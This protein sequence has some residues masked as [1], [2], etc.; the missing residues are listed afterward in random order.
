MKKLA[1][2]AAVIAVGAGAYVLSGKDGGTSSNNELLEYIPADTLLFSGQLTPFPLEDYLYSMPMGVNSKLS[3]E[4]I[5]QAG[6]FGSEQERFFVS[7]Y[8]SYLMSFEN[9]GVFLKTFGLP[10][11]IES[12][13][14]TLGALP[15]FKVQIEDE[16]A[17]WSLLDKA[18][19][20]SGLV[21]KAESIKGQDYRAYSLIDEDESIDMVFSQKEGWLTVTLNTSFN[22]PELLETA[23]GL[24]KVE[25]PIS[26]SG[27]LEEIAS[28]HGFLKD[29]IS[30]INHVELVNGL[31]SSDG[32]MLAKQLTKLV[33]M[34]GS[35]EDPFAE[36]KTS[37]CKAEFNSIAANWPRSVMG[38]KSFS[39]DRKETNFDA[40][41]VIESNNQVILGAL[42][43][44]RGFIPSFSQNINDNVASLAFGMDV[45][46][47][48]PALSEIWKDLQT[49]SYQCEALAQMQ[50]GVSEQNPAMLGMMTGM[51]N[52]VKGIS[53][54]IVDFS[55]TDE[56]GEPGFK[57]LDALISLSA[58][59]PEML[60]NM[61]RPFVPQLANIQLE[62]NGDAID[63]SPY[64]MLPPEMGVT[65]QMAM[66]DN[67]L[68]IFSGDKGE[69]LADK[70]AAEKLEANGLNSVALDYQKLLTPVFSLIEESGEPIP[71]ELA[72]LKDYD[73][74]MQFGLDVTAKGISISTKANSKA[75]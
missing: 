26:D 22:K 1:I 61:V 35:G 44:M 12:Y 74:R 46:Q 8:K 2:A 18:S 4:Q 66:K 25:N 3:L 24:T 9:P 63:V 34:E 19:D 5:E 27:M 37:E 21:H 49:P 53:A 39:V 67:H 50:Y 47:L 65:A 41:I 60:L 42:T 56:N 64:L 69:A 16:N 73:M 17:I 14:Y 6:P 33:Q 45:M 7:L 43:K 58:D 13:T 48:A 36:F 32:N 55:L 23:L 68:V 38:L 40:E 70:L 72:M 62:K 15:V 51:A 10:S 52:G 29:S 31:T 30:F 28:T 59:D 71:E 20:E 54:T 57:H 11:H 75:K